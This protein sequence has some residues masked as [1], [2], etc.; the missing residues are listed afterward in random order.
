MFHEE[1]RGCPERISE[2]DFPEEEIETPEH[3]QYEGDGGDEEEEGGADALDGWACGFRSERE[4]GEEEGEESE[5]YE[6][7]EEIPADESSGCR[8]VFD[9][10]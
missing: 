8:D 1:C 2:R 5:E 10:R 6:E 3:F 7:T 4:R 9:D